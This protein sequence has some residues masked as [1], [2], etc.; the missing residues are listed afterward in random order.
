MSEENKVEAEI[1]RQSEEEKF[2]GVKTEITDT[3]S[4]DNLS[5]EVVEDSPEIPEKKSSSSEHDP[6]EVDNEISELSQRAGDRISHLKYQYSQEQ[7]E[8]ESIKQERNEAARQMKA[9]MSDNQRLQ[10]MLTSGSEALNKQALNNAQWAKHS[11]QAQ[12]KKAYDDG[13]ADA[14]SK[15]QEQL[16]KATLAEQQSPNYA[17][18]LQHNVAQQFSNQPQPQPEEQAQ[19]DPDMQQ[20]A[21]RN[22]WFMGSEPFQREMTAY[23][24][25]VD[26]HLQGSGVD[27]AKEPDRYYKEVDTMMKAQ[28]PSFYGIQSTSEAVVEAQPERRQPSSV[29]APATRNSGKATREIKLEGSQVRLAR[30][31]GIT[32]E[33]Y[34]KEL[35]R[36]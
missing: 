32:P 29:V 30:Q 35:L 13:D 15:A 17:Q 25:W 5:I 1:P 20:W 12:F 28:F 19:P 2:F 31:L 4:G 26:Q 18:Q 21:N 34:A 36:R 24:M 10:A 23:S 3:V 22:P 14:M 8:K 11:A 27:P 7:R 33:Q 16:S 6:S 9:L